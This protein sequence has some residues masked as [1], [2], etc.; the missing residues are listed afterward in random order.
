[1]RWLVPLLIV[2]YFFKAENGEWTYKTI[3]AYPDSLII[4]VELYDTQVRIEFTKD[5]VEV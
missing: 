2:F 4:V 1:M 5:G 3:D